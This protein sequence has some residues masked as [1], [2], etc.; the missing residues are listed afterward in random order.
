MQDRWHARLYFIKPVARLMLAL[1]WI[2]TGIICLTTGREEAMALAR[3]AGLGGLDGV[4]VVVGAL[5]D[6]VIGLALMV[7]ARH[8]R[9]ILLRWRQS[10]RS[11]WRF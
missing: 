11:T 3:H 1:F 8:A 7:Y 5:F 4:A 6:I 9:A 2:A 10:P